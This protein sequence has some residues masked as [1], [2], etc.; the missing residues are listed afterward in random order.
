MLTCCDGFLENQV[1]ESCKKLILLQNSD[2]KDRCEGAGGERIRRV[3][4]SYKINMVY[5][6]CDRSL[7]GRVFRMTAI[8]KAD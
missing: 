1:Q 8:L 5:F 2:L 4:I 6:M 7:Q 3:S